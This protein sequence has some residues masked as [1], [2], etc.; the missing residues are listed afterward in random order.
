MNV[1]KQAIHAICRNVTNLG[2]CAKA[3][4]WWSGSNI[5]KAKTRIRKPTC[6]ARAS[7]QQAARGC[8]VQR[9]GA[10]PATAVARGLYADPRAPA[11]GYQLV[12]QLDAFAPSPPA[13][14]RR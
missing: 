5:R 11:I 14:A 4:G 3:S 2:W 7:P 12:L 9:M 10:K 6:A 1:K 13:V 8:A